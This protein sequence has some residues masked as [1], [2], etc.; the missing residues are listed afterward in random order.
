MLSSPNNMNCS[1]KQPYAQVQKEVVERILTYNLMIDSTSHTGCSWNRYRDYMVYRERTKIW[2]KWLKVTVNATGASQ[3]SP[4]CLSIRMFI[5]VASSWC[6][7]LFAAAAAANY[8]CLVN[9]QI[10]QILREQKQTTV[11]V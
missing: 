4:R 5:H 6:R 11:A 2:F 1:I 9:K 8:H 7:N 10:N 3:L